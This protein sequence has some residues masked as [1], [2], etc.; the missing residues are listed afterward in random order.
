MLAEGRHVTKDFSA[1][2]PT[3]LV[4]ADLVVWQ[5]FSVVAAFRSGTN[6]RR[7]PVGALLAA[8]YCS[9]DC[10]PRSRLR[11]HTKPGGGYTV[12]TG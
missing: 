7:R 6:V 1:V 10:D 2:F 11:D 3:R 9:R 5:L 8:V 12:K 4:A